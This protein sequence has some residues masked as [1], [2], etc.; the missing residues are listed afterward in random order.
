MDKLYDYI[1]EE[2]YE[3]EEKA[4]RD[5]KLSIS[6]LQYGDLLAHF[7]KSLLTAEAMEE[8]DEGYSRRGYSREGGYARE[9]GNSGAGGG[10]YSRRGGGYSYRRNARRNGAGR[11]SREYSGDAE[12]MTEQL[13]GLMADAPNEAVKQDIQKLISK[14]ENM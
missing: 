1:C 13:R 5:H 9:G 8:A 12:E 6:D 2:L 4:G 7:K 10:N 11:Y 14:V 3:L